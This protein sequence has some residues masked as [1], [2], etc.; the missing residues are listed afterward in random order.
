MPSMRHFFKYF[1]NIYFKLLNCSRKKIRNNV[2]FFFSWITKILQN[3]CGHQTWANQRLLSNL[4][5]HST[6]HVFLVNFRICHIRFYFILLY[7]FMIY[8][9]FYFICV[10]LRDKLMA[11]HS[12]KFNHINLTIIHFTRLL[13]FRQLN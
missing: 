9:L 8:L 12:L 10:L 1:S 13:S 5:R 3:V 2:L 6:L 11:V 4:Q 7:Y